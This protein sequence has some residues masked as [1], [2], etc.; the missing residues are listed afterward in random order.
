MKKRK[1]LF[2]M[3]EL[4]GGGAEKVLTDILAQFDYNRYDVTLLL[5]ER[6]GF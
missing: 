4:K 2:I 3:Q 6:V 5:I 1:V